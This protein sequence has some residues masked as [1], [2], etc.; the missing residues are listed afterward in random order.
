MPILPLLALATLAYLWSRRADAMALP[1]ATVIND[2]SEAAP[3]SGPP[4]VSAQDEVIEVNKA[5]A[6][7]PP[8]TA[9]PY[10]KAIAEAEAKHGIPSMML[11][12]LLHQESRF[13]QDIITGRVRSKVGATGIAQFMPATAAEYGIDPVDPFASIDAAG[14]YLSRLYKRFG[15]WKQALAAYNWGQ[16]N[17]A[18]RGLER[19]PTET[20]NYFTQI[21]RDVGV[22]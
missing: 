8:A 13:R 6:W 1:W 20:V 18:R 10:L 15:T 11:A 9:A 2:F 4:E 12:R 19:A 7:R 22:A 17:V 5:A 21:L 14:L 3:V 16:G